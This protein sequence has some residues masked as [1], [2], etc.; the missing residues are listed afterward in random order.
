MIIT[1]DRSR[2]CG[3]HIRVPIAR[4]TKD[5]ERVINMD[6]EELR[7]HATIV[8]IVF[9]LLEADSMQLNELKTFIG[10]YIQ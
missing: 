9:L 6:I 4:T 3:E 5:E 10:S 2:I 8:Y 7:K 1:Q